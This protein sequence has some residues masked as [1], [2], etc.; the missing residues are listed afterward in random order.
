MAVCFICAIAR[1]EAI[2]RRSVTY[3]RTGLHPTS[4]IDD[5]G[6]QA[7]RERISSANLARAPQNVERSRGSD[8]AG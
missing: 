2:A 3:S 6:D 5:P 8:Q 1:G 4:S 7:E